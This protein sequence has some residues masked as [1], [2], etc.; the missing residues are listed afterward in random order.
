TVSSWAWEHYRTDWVQLDPPRH[1]VIHSLE[2]A[3]RAASAAGLELS[4]VEY[5]SG[6][7]QFVGSELYRKD[8]PL[9]PALYEAAPSEIRRYRRRAAALNAAGKGD[10]ASFFFR[11]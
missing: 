1:L 3:R 10:Q 2:S 9:L 8:I 6:H 7:F 11:R 5:D 4:E